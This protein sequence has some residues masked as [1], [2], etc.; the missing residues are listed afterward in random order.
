MLLRVLTLCFR[1]QPRR[2]VF[3]ALSAVLNSGIHPRCFFCNLFPGRGREGKHGKK[4]D[5][6]KVRKGKGKGKKIIEGGK[7]SEEGTGGTEGVCFTG[8]LRTRQARVRFMLAVHGGV[9]QMESEPATTSSRSSPGRLSST[10]QI[11]AL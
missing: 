8:W 5:E 3:A 2:A 1:N 4:K 9:P 7:E 11:K 6:G 10:Q